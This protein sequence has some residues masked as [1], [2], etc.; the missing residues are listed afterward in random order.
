MKVIRQMFISRFIQGFMFRKI[1]L[2]LMVW[3]CLHSS[4]TGQQDD[5]VITKASDER[6]YRVFLTASNAQD[7]ALLRKC[8][9]VHGAYRVV[10]ADAS[11]FYLQ[12]TRT[13][14]Q[15][16]V[17]V[18]RSGRPQQVLKRY[19]ARGSN[20]RDSL[21]RAAD[22]FVQL[23]SGLGGFFASKLL[24]IGQ[25]GGSSQEVY[26]SDL[27]FGEIRQRTSDKSQAVSPRWSPDGKQIIYTSY[28]RSG[29]PDIFIIDAITSKRVPYAT[30]KGTNSGARFSP[31]GRFI[32][33]A[34]SATDNAELYVG[35]TQGRGLKRIT[36][37]DSIESSPT[38]KADGSE[39]VFTSDALGRPQLYRMSASG[40]RMTRIMTNIS[41]YCAE[42]DWNHADPNKIVFTAVFQEGFQIVLWDYQT[43][44]S[45][46]LTRGRRDSIEAVWL[47]DGRHIV[48]TRRTG[49]GKQLMIM[50]TISKQERPLHSARF[51]NISQADAVYVR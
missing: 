9:D 49:S 26:S 2:L 24:F 46:I 6:I 12:V 11:E 19:T 23:T 31:D 8:F 48:F 17:C 35:N 28:Y 22:Q 27:F 38:W 29:F 51:G 42:P 1:V 30:Y 15:E 16:V 3:G 33:M 34:L 25:R 13:S 44:R 39:L 47:R 36:R 32:A 20:S 50:D 5:I 4:L 40:G 10:A 7:T 14:A 37:N 41:R 43:N 45:E 18:I 21:L